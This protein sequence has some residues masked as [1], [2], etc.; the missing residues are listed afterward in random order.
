MKVVLL[1][2][3]NWGIVAIETLRKCDIEIL[4]VFTHSISMDPNDSVWYDSVKKKCEEYKIPVEE[5]ST[6][7]N[8][9]IEEIKKMKPDILFSINWRRL[10]TKE[11]INIPKH[12][13]INIHPSLLPNYRGMSVL[14]WAVLNGETETGVTVHYIDETADTGDI[15]IQKKIP[16]LFEDTTVEVYKKALDSYPQLLTKTVE[17][18]K[19][20]TVRS[21]KQKNL[22]KGFFV[23]KRFPEDGKIFWNFN[24][25]KIYNLTRAL[26][27]PYPNAFFIYNGEKFY[28]KK[29]ELSEIDFRGPPGRIC[30]INEIGMVVT[31]GTDNSQNQGLLI[32]KISLE[33]KEISIQKQFTKLWKDLE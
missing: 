14:N 12:G 33:E 8:Q 3:Q 24:R 7:Q 21:I 1:A 28:V 32:T 15:I 30:L 9:D 17:M 25:L 20:E 23:S 13:C 10:I 4:K 6:L 16:I 5:R 22:E 27:D 2:N 19:N 29:A 18:I 31:C 11:L 26:C